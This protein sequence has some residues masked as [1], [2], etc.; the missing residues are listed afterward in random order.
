MSECFFGQVINNQ[1]ILYGSLLQVNVGWL[2]HEKW[3]N[4]KKYKA[5]LKP[6][7]CSG[8]SIPI[9]CFASSVSCSCLKKSNVQ[10]V[11]SNST[12]TWVCFVSVCLFPDKD[13]LHSLDFWTVYLAAS[14]SWSKITGVPQSGYTHCCY[15]D[16]PPLSQSCLSYINISLVLHGFAFTIHLYSLKKQQH[17]RLNYS[18]AVLFFF[19]NQSLF[20]PLSLCN[21]FNRTECLKF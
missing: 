10:Q 2:L 14:T 4:W 9:S 11:K 7:I 20:S 3:I 18:Y 16:K 13:L 6:E 5:G 17:N 12:N 15:T 19:L 8:N 21:N 1:N